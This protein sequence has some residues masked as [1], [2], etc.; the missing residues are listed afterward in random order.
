MQI[1][2]KALFSALCGLAIFSSGCATPNHARWYEG[3]P[4]RTNE[5][6]LLKLYE[7]PLHYDTFIE[8]ID[9]TPIRKR[10]DC[11]FNNTEEVEL[12]PGEHSL[13]VSYTDTKGG[14]SISNG[15]LTLFCEAGH[16]YEL[17]AASEKR[18]FPKVLSTMI[19]GGKYGWTMWIVDDKNKKVVAGQNPDEI[20]H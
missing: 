20:L 1:M 7:D 18:S 10:F 16:V 12:L 4:R 15:R 6:A 11:A 9:E 13:E 5:V 14:H 17:F 19:F 2:V 8:V 3:S